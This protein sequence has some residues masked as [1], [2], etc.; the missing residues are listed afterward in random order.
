[1]SKMQQVSERVLL[2]VPAECNGR[3]FYVVSCSHLHFYVDNF[4]AGM[5]RFALFASPA[6]PARVKYMYLQ[7]LL[8]AN[9]C[10]NIQWI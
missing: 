5:F 6:N 10:H 8:L 7:R 2:I 3:A 9:K 1:M 4:V